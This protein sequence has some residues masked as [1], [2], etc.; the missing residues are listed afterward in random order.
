MLGLLDALGASAQVL[1]CTSMDVHS[2]D[3][4]LSKLKFQVLLRNGL[5]QPLVKELK[6]ALASE[7]PSRPGLYVS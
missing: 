5:R 2:L 4:A 1:P 7:T 3:N 6:N